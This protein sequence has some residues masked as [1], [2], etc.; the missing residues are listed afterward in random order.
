MTIPPAGF[1]VLKIE[2]VSRPFWLHTCVPPPLCIS[3]YEEPFG[4]E[5]RPGKRLKRCAHTGDW[6]HAHAK[7]SPYALPVKEV[8][9]RAH[10]QQ[11]TGARVD[12]GRAQRLCGLLLIEIAVGDGHLIS[13]RGKTFLES[14]SNG[15]RPMTSTGTANS[16]IHIAAAF[17]LEERNEEFKEAL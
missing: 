15:Y 9:F 5:L 16:N 10:G 4:T 12:K 13:K 11:Q 6:L 8:T 1:N 14:A 3:L 17:S 7:Y 2:F